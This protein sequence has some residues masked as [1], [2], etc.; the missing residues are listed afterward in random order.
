MGSWLPAG[1]VGSAL[2]GSCR[3]SDASLGSQM[4]T[5]EE[6]LLRYLWKLFPNFVPRISQNRKHT[7]TIWRSGVGVNRI[8]NTFVSHN[9]AASSRSCLEPMMRIFTGTGD[10]GALPLEAVHRA[11][12]CLH[13]GW[14]ML[15]LKGTPTGA[16]SLL[17]ASFQS[18]EA[19]ELQW[20]LRVSAHHCESGRQ[21]LTP[22]LNWHQE[23][24]Q[25]QAV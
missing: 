9:C 16:T 19:C 21:S 12:P 14:R 24:L 8:K 17:R 13:G 11:H 7:K 15:R 6:Q 25:V 2:P 3:A 1:T 22:K 18:E 4:K 23:I 20:S 5:V 10:V